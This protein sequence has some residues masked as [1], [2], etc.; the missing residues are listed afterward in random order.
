MWD[1]EGGERSQDDA[2]VESGRKSEEGIL[3]CCVLFGRFVCHFYF[4]PTWES[5]AH[6][7]RTTTTVK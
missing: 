4:E 7:M 3:L 1:R 2:V 6:L 5:S